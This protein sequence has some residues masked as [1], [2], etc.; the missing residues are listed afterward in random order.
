M[1][2]YKIKSKIS[3]ALLYTNDKE[4]EK[5]IGETSPFT[6]GTNHI[7]YLGGN[8][9]QRSER[10]VRQGLMSLKKEIGEDNRK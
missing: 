8:T 9:K 3:V 2:G 7:K 1:A 4:A 5:E 10:P 6:I